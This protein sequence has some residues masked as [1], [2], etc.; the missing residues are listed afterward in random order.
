[1]MRMHPRKQEIA[2]DMPGTQQQQLGDNIAIPSARP[3]GPVSLAL[4]SGRINKE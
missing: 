3:S 1:M 2:C 4:G